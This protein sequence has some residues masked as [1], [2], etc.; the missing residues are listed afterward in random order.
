[1]NFPSREEERGLDGEIPSGFPRRCTR[2]PGNL[3]IAR[4]RA[5]R[6]ALYSLRYSDEKVYG[7]ARGVFCI[8]ETREERCWF[9]VEEEERWAAG[10]R[11]F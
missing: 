10:M 1:M 9:E 11:G 2:A 4:K 6:T 8:R 5:A 3:R 7:R